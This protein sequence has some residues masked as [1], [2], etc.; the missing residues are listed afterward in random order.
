MKDVKC[1]CLSEDYKTEKL[2][3]QVKFSD[4]EETK[5]LL[6]S[7]CCTCFIGTPY[8]FT[9]NWVFMKAKGDL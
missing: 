8:Q 6:D 5:H 3:L 4:T 1:I 9:K 7:F 2:P